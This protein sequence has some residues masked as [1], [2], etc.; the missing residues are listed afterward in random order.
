M[1]VAALVLALIALSYVVTSRYASARAEAEQRFFISAFRD[2]A[3]DE[4]V[5]IRGATY[6]IIGGNVTQGGERVDTFD[7]LPPLRLAYAK[8]LARRSPIMALSGVDPG[9]LVEAVSQLE[10]TADGLGR[11][12]QDARA[13]SLVRTSLYPTDFLRAA[14]AAEQARRAFISSGSD[15]DA[16]LYSEAVARM[17]R[18]YRADLRAFTTAFLSI[19]PKTAAPYADAA[20][21]FD[22]AT[23]VEQLRALDVGARQAESLLQERERCL[24]GHIAACD[25]ID[26]HRVDVAIMHAGE[27]T[28]EY[29]ALAEEVMDI[30][31][32]HGP[33]GGLEAETRPIRLSDSVCTRESGLPLFILVKKLEPGR[34]YNSVRPFYVGDMRFYTSGP[35]TESAFTSYFRSLE[36]TYIFDTP[37]T[38]YTCALLHDDTARI[39]T[40]LDI[41][42]F[43]GD[44]RLGTRTGDAALSALEE[45]LT[46]PD[47]PLYESDTSQYLNSIASGAYH[48]LTPAERDTVDA[49]V[50]SMRDKS[51]GFDEYVRDIARIEQL[52]LHAIE[53]GMPVALSAQ[54]LFL[55]RSGFLGLFMATHPSI[56]GD[57]S[58]LFETN[59]VSRDQQPYVY[60]SDVR[61]DPKER[62]KMIRDFAAFIRAHE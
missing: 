59:Q 21:I 7:A 52:N 47:I 62:D 43:A 11:I 19:V 15:I 36:L 55:I 51:A 54:Y 2:A 6:T 31:L 26:I 42:R 41:A 22:R 17:L 8:L 61:R 32:A 13:E 18:T 40:A 25:A 35:G 28:S 1:F 39:F 20:L 16:T 57:T 23:F 44:A 49:L 14:A 56:L 10:A 38:H 5:V 12:Q 33:Q 27:G 29:S 58:L 46:A 9:S 50:L 53:T 60:Y 48:L 4:S 24:L 37:F 3:L 30:V 34:A 45:R